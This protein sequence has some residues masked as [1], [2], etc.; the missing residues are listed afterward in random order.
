MKAVII[1]SFGE[2]D[3]LEIA[4]LPT[5][6]PGPGEVLI[7]TAGAGVNPVDAKSRKG[8]GFVAES[9]KDKL[10]WTPGFDIA[11]TVVKTGSGVT[12]LK[13]GDRVYGRLDFLSGTGSYAE[14][15]VEK[16]TNLAIAPENIELLYAAA[17]PVAGLTAWQSLFRVGNIQ[18]GDRVLI[19]AA[20]GGVGHFAVQFA[21]MKG[22]YVICTASFRN[23]QF[24]KELG[25]DE[26]VDYKSSD[27]TKVVE[28]VDFILDSMGYE[29]GERSLDILKP[30]GMMV[31]VPTVTAERVCAAGEAKGLNV[32]GIKVQISKSDLG[33]IAELIDNGSVRVFVSKIYQLDQV[34]QAHQDIES[35]STRGKMVLAL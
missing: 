3:V 31:T 6:E 7:K 1:K 9:I 23:R 19:H 16:E 27:F 11:G 17:V 5:P 14:Y 8:M 10:P 29:V 20:A 15:A 26:V 18:E 34:V 4:E 28:P 13:E 22:A 21:K 35:G 32:K 24:L 30:N 12:S 2:P 25:A 33:K